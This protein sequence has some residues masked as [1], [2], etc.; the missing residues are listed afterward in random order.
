MRRVFLFLPAV[1]LFV[2]LAALALGWAPKFGKIAYA[3]LGYNFV[4]S[5]FGNILDLPEWFSK[6]AILNSQLMS[7]LVLDLKSKMY[8][9][10]LQNRQI[11]STIRSFLNHFGIRT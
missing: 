7:I 6:T 3:Y 2:S 5:Y 8:A 10:S 4:I 9:L 11:K 1:L